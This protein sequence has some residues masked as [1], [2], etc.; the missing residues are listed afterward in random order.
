MEYEFAI[1]IQ[2][3]EIDGSAD[4]VIEKLGEAG[5]TDALIGLGQPGY[6]D[7]AFIREAKSKEDAIVS[8]MRDVKKAAPRSLLST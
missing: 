8:A 3:N 4:E 2:L 7:L 6:M 5:C 1:K